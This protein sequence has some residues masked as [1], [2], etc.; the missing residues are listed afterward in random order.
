MAIERNNAGVITNAEQL[1]AQEVVHKRV[2]CPGCHDKVFE[3][4]PEGWDAHS[5][6]KCSGVK[7]GSQ[8]ERKADFKARFIHLFR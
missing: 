4:W 8:E 5:A 1:T 6:F 2:L 3:L 7:S